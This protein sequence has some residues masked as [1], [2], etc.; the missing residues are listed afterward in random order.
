M[1]EKIWK[2]V[3]FL[4]FFIVLFQ[5]CSQNNSSENDKSDTNILSKSSVL[6][7]S[8]SQNQEENQ[9][10]DNS[11]ESVIADIESVIKEYPNGVLSFLSNL[12]LIHI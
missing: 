1:K 9:V 5:F 2:K 3:A 12:S 8:N 7:D 6:E 11:A 4:L 10:K